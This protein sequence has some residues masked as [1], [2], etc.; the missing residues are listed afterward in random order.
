MMP[1]GDDPSVITSTKREPQKERRTSQRRTQKERRGAKEDDVGLNEIVALIREL[2]E[3]QRSYQA[4]ENERHDRDIERLSKQMEEMKADS[5][6]RMAAIQKTVAKWT[7]RALIVTG[8]VI[9]LLFLIRM[10]GP[11]VFR[12]AIRAFLPG[13]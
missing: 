5:D 12:E 13:P 2:G 8:V 6:E 3:T 1:T 11:T 7:Q 9:T 4:R 10:I